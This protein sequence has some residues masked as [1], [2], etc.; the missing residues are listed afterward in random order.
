MPQ[1]IPSR[2]RAQESRARTIRHDG[3][4]YRYSGYGARDGET[5][6]AQLRELY[7]RGPCRLSVA[8]LAALYTR[9]TER[10]PRGDVRL[11]QRAHV[12]L[13]ATYGERFVET[14]QCY[15]AAL[16]APIREIKPG[17]A[18][19]SDLSSI[20][21]DRPVDLR[22]L[23]LRA[24]ADRARA[25]APRAPRHPVIPRR[26][27]ARPHG[28]ANTGILAP[29]PIALEVGV[30]ERLR[31]AHGPGPASELLRE[32]SRPRCHAHPDEARRAART[33]AARTTGTPLRLFRHL[34]SAAIAGDLLI[35]KAADAEATR[36]AELA[37]M[38]GP[39]SERLERLEELEA[40]LDAVRVS[41]DRER[42]A[43]L[44]HAVR[45]LRGKTGGP[46][47]G[48]VVPRALAPPPA[49]ARDPDDRRPAFLAWLSPEVRE[50]LAS[51]TS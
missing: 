20:D 30:L 1:P 18:G 19:L 34:F 31:V 4:P 51:D 50:S 5:L 46:P 2:R 43:E 6:A 8:E 15:G 40:R 25:R 39:P 29:A 12:L 24:K 21:A 17:G 32:L 16:V 13:R 9:R 44:E 49:R 10:C 3:K 41:G 33:L 47:P 48:R 35:D 26:R 38:L 36:R 28:I 11:V 22:D 27:P 45:E 14:A 23:E 7:A 37:G 42:V